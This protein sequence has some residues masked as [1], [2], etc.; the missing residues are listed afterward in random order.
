MTTLVNHRNDSRVI[1]FIGRKIKLRIGFT[2]QLRTA[3]TAEAAIKIS[4]FPE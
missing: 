2:S 1:K 4:I 3:K